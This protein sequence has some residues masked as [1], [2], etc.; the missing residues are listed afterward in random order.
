MYS[1]PVMTVYLVLLGL[2]GVAA[3]KLAVFVVEGYGAPAGLILLA[4]LFL[5]AQRLSARYDL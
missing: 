2:V 1:T 5:V 3:R 4:L